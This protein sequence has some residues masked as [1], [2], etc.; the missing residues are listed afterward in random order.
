MMFTSDVFSAAAAELMGL[1]DIC[2]DDEELEQATLNLAERIAANSTY[3]NQ[4]SKALLS[5]TDVL[6]IQA[7]LAFELAHSPGA[8]ADAQARVDS[9]GKK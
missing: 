6:S 8:C 1:I 5:V 2:V 4:V 7:G 3:S 9:F